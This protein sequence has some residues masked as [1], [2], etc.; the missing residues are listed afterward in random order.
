MSSVVSPPEA[1]ARCLAAVASGESL[2]EQ[3]AEWSAPH[4]TVSPARQVV[5]QDARG[6]R[7]DALEAA[8]AYGAWLRGEGAPVDRVEPAIRELLAA[9]DMAVDRAGR[10][11]AVELLRSAREGY[12]A[13]V[14]DGRTPPA[15]EPSPQP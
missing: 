14:D 10:K 11:M 9:G 15:P 2:C 6:A 12:E 3:Y 1:L 8:R 7:G 13:P 4:D 5:E